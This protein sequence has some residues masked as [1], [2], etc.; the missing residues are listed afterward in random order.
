MKQL[1]YHDATTLCGEPEPKHSPKVR[2]EIERI[3]DECVGYED[4]IKALSALVPERHWPEL[5]RVAL[6]LSRPGKM[7]RWILE[8]A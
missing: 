3:Y 6:K 5:R 1:S 7:E 4:R 8:R 2:S